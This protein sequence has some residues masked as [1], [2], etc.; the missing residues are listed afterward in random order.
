M[1]LADGVMQMVNG[2]REEVERETAILN[3]VNEALSKYGL[4]I[5]MYDFEGEGGFV[6]LYL[7][8]II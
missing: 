4:T 8:K 3:D 1:N 7:D 5:A 6:E 2:I